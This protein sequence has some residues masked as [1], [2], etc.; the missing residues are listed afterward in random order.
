MVV[1]LSREEGS[2]EGWEG[3]EE[4]STGRGSLPRWPPTDTCASLF[5]AA[6]WARSMAYRQ[7]VAASLVTLHWHPGPLPGYAT[8]TPGQCTLQCAHS[9][10]SGFSLPSQR[11]IPVYDV[12]G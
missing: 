7:E 5:T 3:G 9:G 11:Y 4:R 8:L 10:D 6:H 2:Y 1:F 12:R